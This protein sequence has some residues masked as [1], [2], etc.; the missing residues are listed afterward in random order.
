MKE[1]IVGGLFALLAWVVSR[2]DAADSIEGDDVDEANEGGDGGIV[3]ALVTK[4][5]PFKPVPTEPAVPPA[6][7]SSGIG[8]S[9]GHPPNVSA[10]PLGYN[11]ALFPDHRAVRKALRSIG[12]D[13]P[14]E[15]K[16]APSGA[17]MNF[18]VDYNTASQESFQD[19]RGTLVLDGI[20]GKYTLRALEL[21]TN[22]T[23]GFDVGDIPRRVAWSFKFGV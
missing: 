10:D 15:N 17:V 8:N 4:F 9:Q 18:Q 12:Y 7:N 16:L 14:D 6:P 21:A 3:D 11:T 13:A 5:S 2:K 19:A 22:G 1:I 20:P 23:N